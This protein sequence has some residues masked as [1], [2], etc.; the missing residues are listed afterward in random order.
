[1]FKNSLMLALAAAVAVPAHAAST[2]S[3][4]VAVRYSDLDL[5]TEQ[6]QKTLEE[7]LDRAARQVCGLDE[8]ATGTRIA[9]RE[10]TACYR[11]AKE[12]LARQVARV[13]DNSRTG[14]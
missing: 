3:A 10:A 12:Q 14:G 6:G 11:Q 7:R 1:M 5:A 13:V 4:S 8:R 9:G 2:D